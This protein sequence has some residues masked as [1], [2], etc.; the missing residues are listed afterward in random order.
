MF[1]HDREA[2]LEGGHPSTGGGD[3]ACS[4]PDRDRGLPE[5]VLWV[6]YRTLS[7]AAVSPRAPR[8]S[9]SSTGM[10]RGFGNG[11]L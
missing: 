6:T 3:G 5:G 1:S 7:P 2:H 4:R 8:C 10:L 9:Y 11:R